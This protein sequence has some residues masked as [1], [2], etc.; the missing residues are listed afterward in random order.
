MSQ[1][2]VLSSGYT[3][4]VWCLEE[5]AIISETP[6]KAFPVFYNVP[7]SFTLTHEI[8]SELLKSEKLRLPSGKM[9]GTADIERWMTAFAKVVQKSGIEKTRFRSV[10][11]TN[12]E[13]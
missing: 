3:E 9:L 13:C 2:A 1:L 8:A 12:L 7:T 5:L 11:S 10:F 4:S 6:A